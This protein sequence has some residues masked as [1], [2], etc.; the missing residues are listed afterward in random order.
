MRRHNGGRLALAALA[1][2]VVACQT[3]APVGT[4]A[5]AT[6]ARVDS[7]GRLWAPDAR[8]A[9]FKVVAERTGDTLRL[10]G[11]TDQPDALAALRAA[12]P[13]AD[14]RVRALPDDSATARHAL[15]RVAVANVRGTPRQSAELVTQALLGAPVRLLK[16]EGG[17]WYVQTT[18]RYLGWLE[19]SALQPLG[20][21][22]FARWQSA[23]KAIYLPRTGVAT[24]A[25]G[26]NTPAADLV[27]GVV[28]PRVSGPHGV[29]AVQLPDGTVGYLPAADLADFADWSARVRPDSAGLVAAA[30]TLLGVPYLWGGTSSKGLDCSGFTKTVYRMNGWE[31]PRDASQQVRVGTPVDTSN[32]WGNFEPGDLLFFGRPATDST[33]ERVVHVGMWAG[34]R[35]FIHASGQVRISSVDPASPRYDAAERRRYLG[36][37]RMWQPDGR[38]AAGVVPL[39]DIYLAAP[40]PNASPRPAPR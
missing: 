13:A 24:L 10:T 34:N 7:L 32:G 5:D 9:L 33:P 20:D 22:D 30:R 18:D 38:P 17:W 4:N 8:T 40:L 21:V 3:T 25:P 29:A 6:Q 27:G 11:E 2:L 35:T 31:L 16:R 39:A 26:D 15:V 19:T 23:P 1:A 14:V 12:F 37:R 28:L 36:A